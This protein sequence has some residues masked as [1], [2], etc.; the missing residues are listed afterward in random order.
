MSKYHISGNGE[1]AVCTAKVKC[2]LGG[3]SGQENHFDTPDEAREAFEKSMSEQTLTSSKSEKT[4]RKR[5]SKTNDIVQ[6]GPFKG[7][8]TVEAFAPKLQYDKYDENSSEIIDFAADL[9][10]VHKAIDD[11]R[12]FTH[13]KRELEGTP[14]LARYEDTYK[15]PFGEIYAMR[16]R[17]A[18]SIFN[19]LTREYPSEKTRSL[20][21][22]IDSGDNKGKAMRNDLFK[23]YTYDATRVVPEFDRKTKEKLY[24]LPTAYFSMFTDEKMS[25][26][27]AHNAKIMVNIA[28]EVYKNNP[29]FDP[30]TKVKRPSLISPVTGNPMSWPSRTTI[31]KIGQTDLP[32]NNITEQ[33]V[34]D[35]LGEDGARNFWKNDFKSDTPNRPTLSAFVKLVKKAQEKY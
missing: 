17:E 30:H 13:G 16:K 28:D 12:K 33:Y 2:R 4:P 31:Q 9:R 32:S 1:P 3:E 29:D 21:E 5:S 27:N 34:I 24:N 18:D 7:F 23:G 19:H 22:I 10:K 26:L 20:K 8:K 15:E 11:L 35:K 14:E 25:A 6:S